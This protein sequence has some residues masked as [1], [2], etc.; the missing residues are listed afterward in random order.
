VWRIL[1][2]LKINLLYNPA[3]PLLGISPRDLTFCFIDTYSAMSAGLLT[4]LGNVKD[5]GLNIL[6]P[7]NG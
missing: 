3:I 7:V 1:R 5:L 4:T 2:K 6:H